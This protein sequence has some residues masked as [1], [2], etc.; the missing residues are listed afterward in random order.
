MSLA[1]R[2]VERH[3]VWLTPDLETFLRSIASMLEE[4]EAFAFDVLDENGDPTY[5]GW[6]ALLDPDRAP[7]K[8]LPY[9]AQYVGERLPVGISEA[10]AREWIKDAPNQRRGTPLSIFQAAQRKLTGQRRVSMIERY[11]PA[12]VDDPDWLTV[13]TYTS[14]TPDV[15]GTVADLFSVMPADIILQYE[16]RAGQSW[17][18]VKL[19]YA[20]WNAVAAHYPTWGDVTIDIV[21]VST[22]E[23]PVP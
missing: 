5:D 3:E 13:I 12:G 17:A 8:A 7:A 23:R 16:V 1:D 19:A 21:G 20:T 14:E 18:D 11:G 9:L 15:D 10:A 22:Y 2:L 6:T 4:V